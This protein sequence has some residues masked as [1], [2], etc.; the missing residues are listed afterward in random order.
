MIRKTWLTHARYNAEFDLPFFICTVSFRKFHLLFHPTVHPQGKSNSKDLSV[1]GNNFP[2][3]LLPLH[4]MNTFLLP[5]Y[6]VLLLFRQAFYFPYEN[7]ELFGDI[8]TCD[9]S[10]HP[11]GCRAH[12]LCTVGNRR[13]SSTHTLRISLVQSPSLP[14]SSFVTLVSD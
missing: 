14:L 1:D 11:Q 5:L 7:H 9:S 2:F 10:V 6:L 3:S 4:S 12:S 8:T 13:L